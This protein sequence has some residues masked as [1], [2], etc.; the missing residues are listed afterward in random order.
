M[1]KDARVMLQTQ[2]RQRRFHGETETAAAIMVGIFF[3]KRGHHATDDA[4]TTVAAD[5]RN[6]RRQIEQLR[7]GDFRC[8]K[9]IEM[10]TERLGKSFSARKSQSGQIEA[11]HLDGQAGRVENR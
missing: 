6:P 2:T 10:I 4:T 5:N 3:L 11:A 9:N 8:S 1:K 7:A